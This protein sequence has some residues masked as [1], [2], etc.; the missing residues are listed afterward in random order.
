[1]SESSTNRLGGASERARDASLE[2]QQQRQAQQCRRP[3]EQ[4]Q[5]RP[6]SAAV[7]LIRDQE[8]QQRNRSGNNHNTSAT[9]NRRRTTHP[10]S[11]HR[12]RRTRSAAVGAAAFLLLLV[13]LTITLPPTVRDNPVMIAVLRNV[14][15]SSSTGGPSN[16]RPT[17]RQRQW[18]LTWPWPAP[19]PRASRPP[20]LPPGRDSPSWCWAAA[21]GSC[22]KPMRSTIFPVLVMMMIR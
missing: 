7:L 22:R 17:T 5:R 12:H 11:S 6:S 18:H 14:S 2:P 15:R 3:G 20:S 1:M 19:A 8:Q 9:N 4:P 10:S 13:L 21:A 16:K